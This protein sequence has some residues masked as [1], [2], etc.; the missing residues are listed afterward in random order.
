MP[1]STWASVPKKTSSSDRTNRTTVSRSDATGLRM[2][3][4]ARRGRGLGG[5]L[6]AASG[7]R[8]RGAR[9][10]RG[11]GRPGR[12]SHSSLAPLP[13]RNFMDRMNASKSDLAAPDQIG[14]PEQLDEPGL[15]VADEHHD[16]DPLARPG[17]V[18]DLAV[19]AIDLDVLDVLFGEVGLGDPA[20]LRIWSGACRTIAG[21]A[22]PV[23]P[24]G[25]VGPDAACALTGASK[26]AATIVATTSLSIPA[27]LYTARGRRDSA[28]RRRW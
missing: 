9:R 1:A 20:P 23:G 6:G 8:K 10:Q 26:A 19:D 5:A 11:W 13:P 16:D 2:R 24:V 4:R 3:A 28:R 27:R 7:G 14:R 22:G 17:Q 21:A 12:T 25:P 18:D 15:V